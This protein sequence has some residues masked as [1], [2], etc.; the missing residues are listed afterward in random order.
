MSAAKR[1]R[2]ISSV[3]LSLE[4]LQRVRQDTPSVQTALHFNHAGASP[5]PGPVLERVVRHMHRE[6]AVGGYAAADEA[7]EELAEVYR[8][9]AKL[10]GASSPSEI[11]LVESATVAWMKAFSAIPLKEGDIVVVAGRAEYAAQMVEEL[12]VCKDRGCRLEVAPSSSSGAVDAEGLAALLDRLGSK[13]KVVSLTHVPTNGGLVNP[14]EAVGAVCRERGVLYLLDACQSVGQL[15]VNVDRIG[16][17]FLAATGRKFLRAPRGTGFLYARSTAMARVGAPALMDHWAAPLSADGQGYELSEG[18]RRFEYWE[19]SIA[20]RL[21]LG[22]AAKY[23]LEVG[24]AN[25]EARVLELGETLR[26]QLIAKIPGVKVADLGERR[27]GIVTFFF[28][29]SDCIEASF[30]KESLA[31]Q[32]IFVA[33]SPQHQLHLMQS[34]ETC[35]T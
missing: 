27:C 12:R 7:Q 15:D 35:P 34:P 25:V 18:A 5:S 23:F 32:G 26:S 21:G 2:T 3:G 9:V 16:C 19:S 24:L 6:A 4:E 20:G 1:A 29:E 13:V 31:K 30:V 10:I 33:V 11:A 22:V 14:A 17:D 28:E 8:S